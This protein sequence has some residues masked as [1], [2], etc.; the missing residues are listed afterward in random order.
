MACKRKGHGRGFGMKL[1]RIGCIGISD[2]S[3]R[4][5][6]RGPAEDSGMRERQETTCFL[7]RDE[8]ARGRLVAGLMQRSTGRCSDTLH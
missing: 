7:T 4:S 6:G 8:N 5:P 3:L 1:M 2:D